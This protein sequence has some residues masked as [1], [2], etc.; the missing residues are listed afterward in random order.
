M[1]VEDWRTRRREV[2]VMSPVAV[3]WIVV[4]AAC[5]GLCIY[6]ISRIVRRAR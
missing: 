3:F 4:A 1:A 6:G 2:A 5:G